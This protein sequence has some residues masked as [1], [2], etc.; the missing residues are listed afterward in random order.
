MR[1]CGIRVRDAHLKIGQS[2]LQRLS[3][4]HRL[5]L[6]AVSPHAG[7]RQ[8]ILDQ[9]RH[10][11][12]ALQDEVNELVRLAVEFSLVSVPKQRHK[13]RYR[14]Q[15][16]LKVMAGDEGELLQV[17]VRPFQVPRGLPR[18]LFGLLA[19]HNL[20]PGN[21]ESNAMNRPTAMKSTTAT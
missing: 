14:P 18:R 16:L 15:R 10:P 21:S 3:T 1:D 7:I 4:R 20:T 2:T 12:Y 6:L 13:T 19:S 9:L 11:T 5:G 17:V 8:E